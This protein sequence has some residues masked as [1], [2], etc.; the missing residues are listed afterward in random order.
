MKPSK[1]EWPLKLGDKNGQTSFKHIC[2]PFNNLVY[3][4]RNKEF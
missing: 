1:T 3:M 4:L 2:W